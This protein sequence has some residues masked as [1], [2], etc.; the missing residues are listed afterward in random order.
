MEIDNDLM[1]LA[2]TGIDLGDEDA[3]KQKRNKLIITALSLVM[4]TIVTIYLVF[5]GNSLSIIEGRLASSKLAPDFSIDA[6]NGKK[7]IFGNGTYDVLK[8]FYLAEQKNEFKVCLTGHKNGKNYLVIGLY[9]P[10][11]ISQTVAEVTAELCD[12]K[13]I[14]SLHSHPY[15]HCI[16]SDVDI[17]SYETV[18]KINPDAIIGLMCEIDRFGFYGTN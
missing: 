4:L 1:E 5:G 11:T 8:K 15:A 7:V 18:R 3:G 6:G 2:R 17:N 13:T 12:S 9:K 10:K 14:I 16:F